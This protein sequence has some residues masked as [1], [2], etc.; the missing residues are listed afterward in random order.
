M[1]MTKICMVRHGETNWNAERRLQGRTDIP[2]NAAGIKQAQACGRFLSQSE[3]DVVVTSP[4]GR[5]K[6]TAEIINIQL[7]LTILEMEAFIERGFGDAEGMTYEEKLTTFSEQPIPNQ[8]SKEAVIARTMEGLQTLHQKF[9]GE[10]ILLVAH[11]GVINAILSTISNGETGK[12]RLNNACLSTILYK[13]GQWEIESY[14]QV[15]HLSQT[16]D[17]LTK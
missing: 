5:A 12:L 11:G 16:V 3:W 17:N 2:L 13:N 10:N 9:P 7:G 15:S 6:Q 1:E 8:E 4:L 14:N